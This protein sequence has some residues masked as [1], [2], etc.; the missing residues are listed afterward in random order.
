MEK[1]IAGSAQI[2]L[3]LASL[4]IIVAGLAAA[5]AILVPVLLAGFI[6]II[7]SRPMFWLQRK[8]FPVWLS[9][10]LVVLLVVLTGLLIMGRFGASISGFYENLPTYE[11]KIRD[12][13]GA[14]IGWLEQR[15]IRNAGEMVMRVVD[16]GS[17]M[18]MVSYLLNAL[19]HVLTNGFLVM[20]T[21]VFMLL[22][23][24]SFPAKLRRIFGHEAAL[25]QLTE[26]IDNVQRYMAIKM[27]T[28]LATGGLV[29]AGLIA[30]GIDYPLLWGLLAFLL[31]FVPNIGSIVAA[32][33]AVL[34][35]LVQFDAARAGL[36]A[37]GYLIVNL[38]IGCLIEPR[39][40]GRGLGLSTLG[41]F[42]SL[43]FWGWL[44]GPVGMLLAAPLTMI[45]KIAL[46][47]REETRWAAILLGPEG[48]GAGLP[49]RRGKRR[50]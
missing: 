5:K 37:G 17:A 27:L 47:S 48:G 40:M 39:F 28:S 30:I 46:G 21:V 31:N 13:S 50:D 34:L 6:A 9:V 32:I 49:G 12:E 38:V 25:G 23:A 15:G 33:P 18:R 8:G 24:S 10:L 3:L 16:P 41:V 26:F 14:V 19:G 43:L 4:V 42:L 7:G 45:A 2:F 20:M 11:T 36:V 22:E 29:T 35:A 44:L 1:P